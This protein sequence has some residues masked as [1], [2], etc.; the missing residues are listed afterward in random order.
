MVF[1]DAG[2]TKR[3]QTGRSPNVLRH[4][5]PTSS[6][7]CDICRCL[8]QPASSILVIANEQSA[9]EGLN[10]HVFKI[11]PQVVAALRSI[12]TFTP[13]SSGFHYRD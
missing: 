3:E 11:L 13:L 9:R 4:F 12:V 2:T 1:D 8:P 7:T 5:L 10:T 6:P